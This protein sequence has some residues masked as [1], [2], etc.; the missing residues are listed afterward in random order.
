MDQLYIK[1]M[2]GRP[3]DH[4]ITRENMLTAFPHVDLDN[5]PSSDFAVFVRIPQPRLGVYETATCSYEWDGEV[6]KDHWV[7]HPMTPEEKSAKQQAIKNSWKLDACPANWVFDEEK[8]CHEPPVPY[9]QDGKAYIWVQEALK[10]VEVALE[11]EIPHNRPPYPEDGRVYMYDEL[12][13][14]WRLRTAEDE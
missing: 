10:W 4:P 2:N 11:A 3:V 12:N 14:S 1:L 13:N 6:I 5:L 8:C 7:V 9:P